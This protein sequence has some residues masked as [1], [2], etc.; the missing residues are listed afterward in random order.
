MHLNKKSAKM[1]NAQ[2][3]CNDFNTD[4]LKTNA[5]TYL[6]KNYILLEH[7]NANQEHNFVVMT[8]AD[9]NSLHKLIFICKKT[10]CG[11]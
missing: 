2:K 7:F 6:Q 8:N 11:L 10:N 3:N 1:H 5:G 9:L 4:I